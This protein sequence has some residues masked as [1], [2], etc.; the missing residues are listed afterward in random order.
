MEGQIAFDRLLARFDGMALPNQVELQYRP[1]TL[2][3]GL[4]SL[5]VLLGDAVLDNRKWSA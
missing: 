2:M 5:P 4:K 3:R 1:S